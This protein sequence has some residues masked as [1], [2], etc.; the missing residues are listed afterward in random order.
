[1]VHNATPL[2][3]MSAWRAMAEQVVCR[4]LGEQPPSEIARWALTDHSA[5]TLLGHC[6]PSARGD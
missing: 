2:I 1:M 4:A 6:S 3:P 5:D